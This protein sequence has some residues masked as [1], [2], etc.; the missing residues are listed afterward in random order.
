MTSVKDS[1]N[2]FVFLVIAITL[3]IDF[4]ATYF[5]LGI[6]AG[7]E[8]MTTNPMAWEGSVNPKVFCPF[9]PHSISFARLISSFNFFFLFFFG[10]KT[11]RGLQGCDVSY[12]VV[13]GSNV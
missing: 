13:T 12:F 7:L 8:S 4:S 1:S 3:Y 2:H 11:S 10:N 6:G 9:F 5:C